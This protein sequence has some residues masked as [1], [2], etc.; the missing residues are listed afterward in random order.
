MYLYSNLDGLFLCSV[1][2]GTNLVP[3]LEENVVLLI[4]GD[5]V[6]DGTKTFELFLD[7][8]G[9]GCGREDGDAAGCE[10]GESSSAADFDLAEAEEGRAASDEVWSD[11]AYDHHL[12][13][14]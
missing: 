2:N 6:L 5:D 10:F 3:T 11:T 14:V 8:T 12:L 7:G 1:F 9:Q 4:Y 13:G